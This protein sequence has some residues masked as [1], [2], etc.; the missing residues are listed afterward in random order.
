MSKIDWFDIYSEELWKRHKKTYCIGDV[1]PNGETLTKVETT[2]R[3][4][5]PKIIIN[6]LT[7]KEVRL[8]PLYCKIYLKTDSLSMGTILIIPRKERDERILECWMI[9]SSATTVIK[10]K[11]IFYQA[12]KLG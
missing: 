9:I 1:L 3:T 2:I 7:N 4:N 10:S 6:P 8:S 5:I 12:V 11:R